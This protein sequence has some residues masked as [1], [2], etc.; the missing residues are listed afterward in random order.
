MQNKNIL[1]VSKAQISLQTLIKK[2]GAGSVEK[3]EGM[4]SFFSMLSSNLKMESR[5]QQSK[6]FNFAD[7]LTLKNEEN[8]G[9]NGIKFTFSTSKD[10]PFNINAFETALDNGIKKEMPQFGHM[11]GANTLLREEIFT[12]LAEM[13]NP[14]KVGKNISRALPHTSGVKPNDSLHFV[15][16]NNVVKPEVKN[17]DVQNV[18]KENRV[19]NSVKQTLN[20]AKENAVTAQ[21][22]KQFKALITQTVKENAELKQT[23]QPLL[24]EPA[25]V[26][27]SVANALKQIAQLEENVEQSSK[28]L[29]FLGSMQPKNAVEI[30]K[31]EEGLQFKS[32]IKNKTILG[33]VTNWVS[34]INHVGISATQTKGTIEKPGITANSSSKTTKMNPIAQFKNSNYVVDTKKENSGVEQLLS[35][36]PA[37]NNTP[38]TVTSSAAQHPNGSFEKGAKNHLGT[39]SK[40]GA[41]TKFA[42]A[43]PE[44]TQSIAEQNKAQEVAPQSIKTDAS[45]SNKGNTTVLEN[46][47]GVP[48]GK[49]ISNKSS[50][51]QTVKTAVAQKE[52]V[53][54]NNQA[55]SLAAKSGNSKMDA[56]NKAENKIS[57][58]KVQPSKNIEN[59]SLKQTLNSVENRANNL[60]QNGIKKSNTVV[61]VRAKA[62]VESPK[63]SGN[64]KVDLNPSEE[65][66]SVANKEVKTVQNSENR[67]VE[68]NTKKPILKNEMAQ[69]G[70]LNG[71]EQNAAKKTPLSTNGMV[72][73]NKSAN[74]KPFVNENIIKEIKIETIYERNF[75][76]V[77]PAKNQ[78][79]I[80]SIQKMQQQKA[81]EAPKINNNLGKAEGTTAH[82]L[83][84]EKEVKTDAKPNL[85]V[86]ERSKN[87][88]L[89][90]GTVVKKTL[91]NGVESTLQKQVKQTQ[92][93]SNRATSSAKEFIPADEKQNIP[94]IVKGDVTN[95]KQDLSVKTIPEAANQNKQQAGKIPAEIGG[96]KN[97]DSPRE[98]VGEKTK[99]EPSFWKTKNM[100]DKPVLK[101][102][103]NRIDQ[104]TE[105]KLQAAKR[106]ENPAPALQSKIEVQLP[107]KGSTAPVI[108]RAESTEQK[109]LIKENS[110]SIK[111][112]LASKGIQTDQIKIESA[113][114]SNNFS[115]EG[116][117]GNKQ[118]QMQ[119]NQMQNSATAQKTE[120]ELSINEKVVPQGVENNVAANGV[121]HMPKKAA[122]V[123]YLSSIINSYYNAKTTRFSKSNIVV[124]A[125]KMGA[126]DIQ[127]KKE[128]SAQTITIVVENEAA[129]NELIKLV[130][131]ITEN[132]NARG[133]NL[134]NVQVDVGQSGNKF[135]KKEDSKNGEQGKKLKQGGVAEGEQQTQ[136]QNSVFY[137]Y[138]S[139]DIIA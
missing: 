120:V 139:M 41:A 17:V 78:A 102:V 51:Q 107:E 127:L 55:P 11:A 57:S 21:E 95:I 75:N 49:E 27:K 86:E 42:T 58:Q 135:A 99:S 68:T 15:P 46:V 72:E 77:K 106:D 92:N 18:F 90:L 110:A 10:T 67:A 19:I 24:N 7:K 63:Q 12:D 20:S 112:Y 121:H 83:G 137:G 65:L 16:F 70:G 93:E 34:Q 138:N 119:P 69:S 113:A 84:N 97:I 128:K 126:L 30:T 31:T 73:V 101:M 111:E 71:K 87:Q 43:K 50:L 48:T 105:P 122:P 124:D 85:V 123:R 133:M 26:I 81:T 134:N 104:I 60:A 44:Q 23:L 3:S 35:S 114:H 103:K 61:F 64:S 109:Q 32:D 76:P 1:S 13:G 91:H 125:G 115:Q 33:K 14:H 108:I 79:Q 5:G 39:A 29:I 6:L 98:V 56:L 130:P 82:K 129:K 66:K 25:K 118:Q 4:R 2:I 117:F 47:K 80:A 132:L 36:K 53:A 54:F 37:N 94:N 131:Q 62:N 8:S 38:F 9:E 100:A 88:N 89:Q 22:V 40:G 74:T 116:S 136:K 28:A 52:N 59:N 45:I 96:E